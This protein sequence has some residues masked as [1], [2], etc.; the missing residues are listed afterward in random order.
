MQ[1]YGM[2]GVSGLLAEGGPNIAEDMGAL[3]S[4]MLSKM[5]WDVSLAKD[6]KIL[7]AEFL[8]GY[9]GAAASSMHAYLP[10]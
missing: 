2:H 3:K 9:Y 6:W 1:L 4:W 8:N 5:A 7:M 10:T